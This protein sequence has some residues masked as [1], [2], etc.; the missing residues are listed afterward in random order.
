MIQDSTSFL[1]YTVPSNTYQQDIF[2]K[3][4][5]LVLCLFLCGLHSNTKPVL[6][7]SG[8]TVCATLPADPRRASSLIHS[9]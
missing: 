6:Q 5:F 7:R 3:N 2:L 8:I 4:V 9:L 1:I